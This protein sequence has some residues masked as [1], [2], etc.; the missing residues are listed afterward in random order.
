MYCTYRYVQRKC[1]LVK[2]GIKYDMIFDKVKT[3]ELV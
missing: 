3:E 2:R 1:S